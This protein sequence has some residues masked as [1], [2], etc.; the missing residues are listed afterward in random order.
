M[1]PAPPK[2]PVKDLDYDQGRQHLIGL[3]NAEIAGTYAK[4][5]Q[6][7]HLYQRV[8]IDFDA[9]L[10]KV[11]NRIRETYAAVF[12]S[13]WKKISPEI[14][15]NSTAS[16]LE[17][18][19]LLP[20]NVKLFCRT[21]QRREPYRCLS[22]KDVVGE[23]RTGHLTG[24]FTPALA[25]RRDFQLFV[26]AFRCEGCAATGKPEILVL[27]R[28]AWTFSLDGRSPIEHI[29][30]PNFIPEKER[31][32]YRNAVIANNAGKPLAAIFYLRSFVEQF[33]RR[34]TGLSGKQTGEVITS[35]YAA[36]LPDPLRDT[37]PSL[38]E[39]YEKLSVPIHEAQD[40]DKTFD[41]A[42]E[43]I[44]K[45]FEIRKVHD[46]PEIMPKKQTEETK[47]AETP[48]GGL[49]PK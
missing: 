31:P 2:P 26:F 30:I 29:E 21:C 18:F 8:T 25:V 9:I 34:M 12:E 46:I 6:E 44:N 42:L 14:V 41:A 23:L 49:D 48:G 3:V 13:G 17:E 35:A 28:E 10:A 45:H 37:M 24:Q 40:D 19:Q 1:A 38:K 4:I 47:V 39:W 11:R 5:L 16:R 32:L 36:T 7:K 27:R 15:L 20:V 22:A 43:R 33:T